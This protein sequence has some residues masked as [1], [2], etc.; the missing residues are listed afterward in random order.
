MDPVK[1]GHDAEVY[2]YQ[3]Q[4]V[5]PSHRPPPEKPF[6]INTPEKAKKTK[7]DKDSQKNKSSTNCEEDKA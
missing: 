5:R 3:P 1:F 7:K 6:E 4:S 2:I